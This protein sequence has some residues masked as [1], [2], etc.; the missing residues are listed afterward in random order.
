MV[1]EG[2][3]PEPDY[4]RDANLIERLFARPQEIEIDLTGDNELP[5]AVAEYQTL[6][7][8]IAEISELRKARRAEILFKLK[9]A[10]RARI[11]TGTITAKSIKRKGYVV[12]P[13]TY[14]AI[15]FRGDVA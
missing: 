7:K 9:D 2:R 6:G 5:E 11:A 3:E 15:K 13:S 10:T 4:G 14:R 1:D 8:S 12:E